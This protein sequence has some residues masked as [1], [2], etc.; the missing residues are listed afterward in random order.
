M[1]ERGCTIR[2]AEEFWVSG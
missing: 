1:K 2:Q